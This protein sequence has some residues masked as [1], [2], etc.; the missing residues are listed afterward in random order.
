[1][2]ESLA[3]HIAVTPSRDVARR[4]AGVASGKS[5]KLIGAELAISEGTVK[6]HM[7]SNLPK[8]DASILDL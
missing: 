6:T 4:R 1:M 8:L 3:E 5:N 7:K 2:T